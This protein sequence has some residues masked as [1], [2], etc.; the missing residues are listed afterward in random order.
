MMRCADLHHVGQAPNVSTAKLG[1]CSDDLNV[2]IPT[3]FHNPSIFN[4]NGRINNTFRH[5]AAETKT[6]VYNDPWSHDTF[7]TLPETWKRLKT[8][9][10]FQISVHCVLYDIFNLIVVPSS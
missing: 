2:E 4:T 6:F 3:T 10:I 8:L 1:E 5:P 7:L 9:M